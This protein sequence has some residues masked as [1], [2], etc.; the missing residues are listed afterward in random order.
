V[1]EEEQQQKRTKNVGVWGR[2][3]G[4]RR[5]KTKKIKNVSVGEYEGVEERKQRKKN[6]I[7]CECESV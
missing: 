1:E 4:F 2:Y 6:K 3:E 7:N 5:K